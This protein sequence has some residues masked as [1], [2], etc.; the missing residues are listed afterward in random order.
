MAGIDVGRMISGTF[1]SLYLD[2]KWLTNF[3][4]CEIKDEFDYTELKL[5]G[6]R[7]VKHK[8]AGVKGSGTITGYKVTSELQMALLKNPLRTFEIISKLDDPEA[9]EMERIRIP[10]VKFSANQLVKWKTGEMV[11]EEWTFVFDG[12]P[13]LIDPIMEV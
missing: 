10:N 13:E 5:S 7:R 12:E 3:T 4:H 11:E 6:D 1:G 2:G 8:L 9:Y